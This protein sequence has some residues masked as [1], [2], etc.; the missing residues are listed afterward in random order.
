M[1][2]KYN[3]MYI[4][5]ITKYCEEDNKERELADKDRLFLKMIKMQKKVLIMKYQQ[6]AKTGTFPAL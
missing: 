6:N 5:D 3:T 4:N 2:Q 1:Y